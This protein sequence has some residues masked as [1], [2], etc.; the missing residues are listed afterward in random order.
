MLVHLI[1]GSMKG[2]TISIGSPY[3]YTKNETYQIRKVGCD[4]NYFY[5][6]LGMFGSCEGATD[7]PYDI[8]GEFHLNAI[9]KIKKFDFLQNFDDW[10][11]SIKYKIEGTREHSRLLNIIKNLNVEAFTYE[12]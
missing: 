9:V 7:F 8:I 5:I 11:Q 2:K 1:D 12:D 10:F 4:F 6:H 3:F